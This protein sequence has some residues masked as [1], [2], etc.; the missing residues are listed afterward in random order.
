[1][2]HQPCKNVADAG[3]PSF[4]TKQSIN[5]AAVNYTAHAVHFLQ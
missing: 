1:M 3:L 5:N 2:I 4:L